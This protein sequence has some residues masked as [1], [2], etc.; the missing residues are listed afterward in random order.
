MGIMKKKHGPSSL[1]YFFGSVVLIVTAIVATAILNRTTNTATVQDVRT[2][3]SVT[4]LM[5]MSAVI[6]SVDETGGIVVVNGLQFVGNAPE[7]LDNLARTMAGEWTVA[8]SGS[9]NLGSLSPGARVELQVNPTTL[10]IAE[11]SLTAAAITVVQ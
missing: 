8:V 1:P 9:V 2:R 3:A 7:S 11:H 4:S 5:R 10:T 6:T